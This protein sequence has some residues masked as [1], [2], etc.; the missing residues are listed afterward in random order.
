[1]PLERRIKEAVAA[2]DRALPLTDS[3]PPLT[4]FYAWGRD[5]SAVLRCLVR[6][7]LLTSPP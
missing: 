1:M 3:R 6:R 2:R 7:N 5:G 4:L